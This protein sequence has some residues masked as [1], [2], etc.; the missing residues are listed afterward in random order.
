MK[1]I[2]KYLSTNER[3]INQ[4]SKTKISKKSKD[5]VRINQKFNK[6]TKKSQCKIFI[7]FTVSKQAATLISFIKW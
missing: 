2:S 3:L 6:M 1:T 4:L 7:N 5:Q